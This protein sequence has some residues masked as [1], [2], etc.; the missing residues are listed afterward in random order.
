M[1]ADVEETENGGTVTEVVG[2]CSNF[3]ESIC[4]LQEVRE[5]EEIRM[6]ALWRE[7]KE[8]RQHWKL[9]RFFYVLILDLAASLVDSA[10]DFTHS[11]LRSSYLHCYF[12]GN[13]P[14][15][16][17]SWLAWGPRCPVLGTGDAGHFSSL[18]QPACSRQG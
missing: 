8:W 18:F 12:H 17:A 11:L 4:L 9:S 5:T 6:G 2:Q 10:T 7:M 13:G 1:A 14:I 16:L 15:A 3:S